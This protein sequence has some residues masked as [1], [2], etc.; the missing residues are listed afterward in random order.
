MWSPAAD[1]STYRRNAGYYLFPLNIFFDFK[2]VFSL[3][4]VATHEGLLYVIGGYDGATHLNSVEVY[5]PITNSWL[6][7]P[8]SM[9]LPRS[10]FGTAI[11]NRPFCKSWKSTKS[12]VSWKRCSFYFTFSLLNRVSKFFLRIWTEPSASPFIFYLNAD[13]QETFASISSLY[14]YYLKSKETSFKYSFVAL[15]NGCIFEWLQ[16]V[17][18]LLFLC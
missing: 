2:I 1:M 7:L 14:C 4:G 12:H 11:V 13:Y 15:L 8:S 18:V 16:N 6:M 10:Y 17:L 5:N 9:A 3:K